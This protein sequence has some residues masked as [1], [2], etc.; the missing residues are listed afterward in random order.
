[1]W[2]TEIELVNVGCHRRFRSQLTK[3]LVGIMGRNGA[4]KSTIL[5]AIAASLSGDVIRYFGSKDNA[6][7]IGSDGEESFVK[8]VME[9]RGSHK[10][11][12]RRF[13]G[14]PTAELLD[15]S[16]TKTGSV[17][18]LDEIRKWAGFDPVSSIRCLYQP[19]WKLCSVIQA[20]DTERQ[21]WWSELCCVESCKRI[22]E[23]LGEAEQRLSVGAASSV[24]E[25]ERASLV[26]EKSR[27][28]EQ[29]ADFESSIV[30]TKKRVLSDQEYNELL[31][32]VRLAQEA[33]SAYCEMTLAR[34]SALEQRKKVL[35]LKER[36]RKAAK[37]RKWQEYVRVR[38]ELDNI[39]S[40][41]SRLNAVLDQPTDEQ[42]L[43]S[44]IE[45]VQRDLTAVGRRLAV[46]KAAGVDD[47]T[48]HCPVCG[49]DLAGKEILKD[50]Q[51]SSVPYLESLHE[52]LSNRLCR[53]QQLAKMAHNRQLVRMQ[54]EYE[55]NRLLQKKKEFLKRLRNL[56]G[57]SRPVEEVED[58]QSVVA[59]LK[60]ERS[61]LVGMIEVFRSWRRKY[62]SLGIKRG[63]LE[64]LQR[65]LEVHS[66]FS[67]RL[68]AM[69]ATLVQLRARLKDLVGRI[70]KLDSAIER[71][72]SRERGLAATA[73]VRKLFHPSGI[74]SFLSSQKAMSI[75]NEANEWLRRLGADFSLDV[76]PELSF[77]AVFP[78]R[79]LD[80]RRLSGGQQV[81][82]SLA[83]WLAA[84]DEWSLGM[85]CLFLDEP[86]AYLDDEYCQRLADTLTAL[87][88]HIRGRRQI[89]L[90]THDSN[91]LQCFDQVIRIDGSG[92]SH[93][94]ANGHWSNFTSHGP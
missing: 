69:E 51:R 91:L 25:C 45:H 60:K 84:S 85:E 16:G 10:S 58:Y 57:A 13:V 64:D 11:L 89:L 12:I 39:Q 59:R 47:Q 90:V 74:P 2:I 34:K 43:E 17:V 62:E 24:L 75:R 86:T 54:A 20:S 42:D 8:I 70:S 63:Q 40:D 29:I 36:C 68:A 30:E 15:E 94:Q 6:V 37:A 87:S 44:Q 49:S 76:T 41:I 50:F 23:L 9:H 18:V 14:Q 28:E 81:L 93:E 66:E 27:L 88:S 71:S 77:V 19:Q 55:L 31:K 26:S 73:A 7:R 3:G 82:A 5:N 92:K 33:D 1:M 78:G 48:S 80:S 4:G 79:T 35:D 56:R 38:S 83:I 21:R 53:L 52:E 67:Q 22:W 65:R 61:R 46:L 32:A 72:V